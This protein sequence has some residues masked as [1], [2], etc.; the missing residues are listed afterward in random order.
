MVSVTPIP[1]PYARNTDSPATTVE[2]SVVATMPMKI[3]RNSGSSIAPPQ[4]TACDTGSGSAD[5]RAIVDAVIRLG[6]DLGMSIAAE[7]VETEAEL[8]FLMAERCHEAQGYLM[9]RP[10][11]IA[12]FA[13]HT[14]GTIPVTSD[15]RKR[16]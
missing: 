4:P 9:G 1:S 11:P 16:A 6:H 10:S 8:G 12:Q 2:S 3:T 15:D 13:R 5:S 7:G 14:H